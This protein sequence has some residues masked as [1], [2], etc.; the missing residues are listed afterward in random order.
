MA[1]GELE[2]KYILFKYNQFARKGF[3]DFFRNIFT[4]L[5]L[6]VRDKDVSPPF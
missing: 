2:H 4:I 6:A 3:L 5:N 1:F